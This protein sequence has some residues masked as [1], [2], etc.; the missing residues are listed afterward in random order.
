MTLNEA[1]Q[2]KR[3][4]F[5]SMGLPPNHHKSSIYF[6]LGFHGSAWHLFL[7]DRHPHWCHGATVKP[8]QGHHALAAALVDFHGSADVDRDPAGCGAHA[9]AWLGRLGPGGYP[10]Q[11]DDLQGKIPEKM[12]GNSM[13]YM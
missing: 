11:M 5:L 13:E 8:A 9:H 6:S 12:D 3:G 7:W 1:P 10:P 2:K 4:H